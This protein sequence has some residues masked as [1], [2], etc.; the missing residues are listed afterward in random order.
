MVVISIAILLG[1]IHFPLS[2]N[3][4][5]SITLAER[6]LSPSGNPKSPKRS[7]VTLRKCCTCSGSEKDIP[8]GNSC[9]IIIAKRLPYGIACGTT[10]SL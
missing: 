7:Y 5:C 4:S 2:H 8:Y 3:T 1:E 9:S 6:G 10:K